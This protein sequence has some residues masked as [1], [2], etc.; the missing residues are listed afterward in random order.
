[1]KVISPVLDIRTAEAN[2]GN[3]PRP[4]L[5]PAGTESSGR[6]PP[7]TSPIGAQPLVPGPLAN[8]LSISV[9]EDH[10]L[11]I[12]TTVTVDRSVAATIEVE[13]VIAPLTCTAL[14][15]ITSESACV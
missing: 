9:E 5:V 8:A 10:E 1:M 2:S 11:H 14:P 7:P 6:L 15:L 3:R 12:E 4:G 13:K